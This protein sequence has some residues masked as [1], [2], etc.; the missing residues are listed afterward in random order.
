MLNLSSNLL[1]S[2]PVTGYA[3][4]EV[5]DLSGNRLSTVPQ[6]LTGLQMPALRWLSL[7]NNAMSHVRFP[8]AAKE[9]QDGEVF[10]NLTWV[11]VSHM[12]ELEELEAGAFSGKEV[13]C[14]SQ[15]VSASLCQN[16]LCRAVPRDV[17][18]EA[19]QSVGGTLIHIKRGT[20]NYNSR[21][22]ELCT[23]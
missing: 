12:K 2:F 23:Y 21:S 16:K 8:T 18:P 22:A 11:S 13:S 7:D 3:A 4:L 1:T 19:E 14:C 6:G 10:V 15:W 17:R 20:C 9:E 5:L